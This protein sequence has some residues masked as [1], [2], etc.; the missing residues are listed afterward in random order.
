MFLIQNFSS[1][2]FWKLKPRRI[3]YPL[4]PPSHENLTS[5]MF[6]ARASRIALT[7]TGTSSTPSARTTR[8]RRNS[9]EWLTHA[10]KRLV[11]KIKMVLQVFQLRA[12][13]VASLGVETYKRLF[14]AQSRQVQAQAATAQNQIQKIVRGEAVGRTLDKDGKGRVTVAKELCDHPDSA[15]IRGANDNRKSGGGMKWW[16][17]ELCRTRWERIPMATI[18]PNMQDVPKDDDLL[19][20]GRYMGS[21]YL[22]VITSDWPYC[23]WV[24]TTSQQETTIKW[25]QHFALYILAQQTSAM[26]AVDEELEYP[27]EWETAETDDL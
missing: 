10:W 21:T 9:P 3:R 4:A 15:M 11:I 22:E 5:V 6:S 23:E 24:V 17:C 1:L 19:T 13:T 27:E 26:D 25:L 2:Q 8:V 7:S 20:Q 12:Q 18:A 16:T 14:A